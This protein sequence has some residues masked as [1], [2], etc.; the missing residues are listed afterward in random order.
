MVMGFAVQPGNSAECAEGLD[1]RAMAASHFLNLD[2]LL[3][4]KAVLCLTGRRMSA[5]GQKRKLAFTSK[6]PARSAGVPLHTRPVL[7]RPAYSTVG[8][9]ARGRGVR[10]EPKA[11]LIVG[12]GGATDL[13]VEA[14]IA[15]AGVISLF[16]DWLR[17]HLADG[18]L[19]PVLVDWWQSFCAPFLYRSS[20][21][22]VPPTLRAFID[23][24]RTKS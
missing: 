24:I 8:V 7:E 3:D 23:D 20:R 9:R 17:P 4:C 6:P 18:S 16:E 11:R 14:E 10:I 5:M 22:L 19:E 21:C 13:A 1:K 15:G 12:I 2:S